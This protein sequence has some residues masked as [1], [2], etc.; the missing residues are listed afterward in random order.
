MSKPLFSVNRQEIF[1]VDGLH[2]KTNW[3]ILAVDY[4]YFDDYY[5]WDYKFIPASAPRV[6]ITWQAPVSHPLSKVWG[7]ERGVFKTEGIQ[8]AI[9][10]GWLELVAPVKRK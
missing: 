4:D 5:R 10:A 7:V 2:Y 6:F 8:D 1:T 3:G 9:D